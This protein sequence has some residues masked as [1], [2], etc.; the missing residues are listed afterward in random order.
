MSS[1]VSKRKIKENVRNRDYLSQGKID[2][3][4][5]AGASSSSGGGASAS[6][7]SGARSNTLRG[8]QKS[9]KVHFPMLNGLFWRP[10]VISIIKLGT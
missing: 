2:F 3:E 5:E 9:I 8:G 1:Q 4:L 6:T 10:A 7:R